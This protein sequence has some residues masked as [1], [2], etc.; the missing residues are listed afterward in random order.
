MKKCWE[1]EL[2]KIKNYYQ[3]WTQQMNEKE[4][5]NDERKEHQIKENIFI[6]NLCRLKYMKK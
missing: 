3:M 2:N 5:E 4:R 1:A 6:D